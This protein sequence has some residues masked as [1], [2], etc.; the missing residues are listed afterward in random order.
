MKTGRKPITQRKY[1][2]I[3]T[4]PKANRKKNALNIALLIACGL[5]VLSCVL[6]LVTIL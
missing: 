4:L 1:T 5:G 3:A 2:P 6:F